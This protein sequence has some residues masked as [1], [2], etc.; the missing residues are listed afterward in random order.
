LVPAGAVTDGVDN[1]A[2]DITWSFTTV[3]DPLACNDPS[4]IIIS[5]ITTNEATVSWTENGAG[6]EWI[7]LYGPTGFDPMT[8]GDQV[9]VTPDPTTTLIELTDD[10]EYDVYVQAICGVE[11]SGWAGPVTFSTLI[12]CDPIVTL[13]FSEDFEAGVFPPACWNVINTHPSENWHQ[14]VPDVGFAA[15]VTYLDAVMMD[16]WLISP[17]FDLSAI[18][19]ELHVS[20]SFYTSYY[21]L[22]DFTDGADIMLKVSTDGGAT[23]TELWNE[24]DFGVFENFTWYSATIPFSAYAGESNV[25]IAFHYLGNDGAQ[26]MIDNIVIDLGTEVETDVTNAVSIYPNPSNDLVNI[27]VTE[28]SIVSVV[29]IAGRNIATFNVNANEEVNF[30]QSAGMY[31]VKVESNGKVYTQKLVIE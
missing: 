8:E 2:N 10:T 6:T 12:Y 26:T 3:L 18:S 11:T 13:P 27:A 5:D 9:T 1:L 24:E 19:G 29:D 17:T 23:W 20:F 14:G 4:D 15:E 31:F 25:K 16:E 30:T 21:W 7:V 28:N 22:V